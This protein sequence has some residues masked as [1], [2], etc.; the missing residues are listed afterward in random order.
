M[1]LK[2]FTSYF[3]SSRSRAADEYRGELC[4]ILL[5]SIRSLAIQLLPFTEVCVQAMCE[6]AASSGELPS[7]LESAHGLNNFYGQ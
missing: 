6:N 3:S 5:D 7:W 4:D 1:K 2:Q